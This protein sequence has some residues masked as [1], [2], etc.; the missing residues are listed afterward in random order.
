MDVLV[1]SVDGD[2]I[3]GRGAHQAPEVDGSTMLAGGDVTVRV[4][5]LVR[6]K[7]VSTE[8]VDLIAVPVELLDPSPASAA[9]ARP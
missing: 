2:G 6:A 9:A 5:D 1:E 8:G 7:V 3:E 4:G